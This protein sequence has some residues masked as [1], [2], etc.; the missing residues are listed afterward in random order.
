LSIYREYRNLGSGDSLQGDKHPMTT[1]TLAAFLTA[2]AMTAMASNHISDIK[3]HAAKVQRDSEYVN[4]LL[5]TKQPDVDALRQT[6]ELTGADIAKLQQLVSDFEAT[7][8]QFSPRDEKEWAFLKEKVQLLSI[9]YTTKK[10]LAMADN[11]KSNR[12]MIRAHAEGLAKRA[13][14]LQETAGRIER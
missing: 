1:R 5:K 4:Q 10:E 8:P 11:L 2:F 7:N 12:G 9:F 14:M 3:T 13:K 6:I